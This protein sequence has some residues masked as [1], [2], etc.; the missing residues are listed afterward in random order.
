MKDP[1]YIILG[2]SHE[3]QW[4][5][6]APD[7]PLRACIDGLRDAICQTVDAHHVKLIAEEALVSVPTVACQIAK[8]KNIPYVQF[9]MRPH[10]WREAGICDEMDARTGPDPQKYGADECR[11]PHA[12]DIREKLWLDKIEEEGGKPVLLVC[13]WAHVRAL[14]KKV[15]ERYGEHAEELFY[16]DHLRQMSIVDLFVDSAENVRVCGR[17][18]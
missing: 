3:I 7:I 14:S 11:F 9:D 10:E 15:A 8:G 2:T 17:P 6:G 16:P 1:L 18:E 4:E 5:G 12:D 13:G